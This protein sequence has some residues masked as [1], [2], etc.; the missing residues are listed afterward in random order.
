MS[1]AGAGGAEP[2]GTPTPSTTPATTVTGGPSAA[3]N[4]APTPLTVAA[5]PG[6]P[7]PGVASGVASGTGGGGVGAGDSGGV[8]AVVPADRWVAHPAGSWGAGFTQNVAGAEMAQVPAPSLVAAPAPAAA[9]AMGRIANVGS[10]SAPVA[11][12]GPA[13]VAGTAATV[14]GTGGAA[15]MAVD[16]HRSATAGTAD[17]GFGA[18]PAVAGGGAFTADGTRGTSRSGGVDGAGGEVVGHGPV[19]GSGAVPVT[20]R[21]AEALPGPADFVD[22]GA[23][24]PPALSPG[25]RGDAT[26][27]P[28][29]GAGAGSSPTH[30][31][32]PDPASAAVAPALRPDPAPLSAAGT[33]VTGTGTGAGLP[34]EARLDV[35]EV[36]GSHGSSGAGTE[37]GGDGPAASRPEPAQPVMVDGLWGYSQVVGVNR[38]R[39]DGR[40][41]GYT[42]NCAAAVVATHNTLIS[43]VSEVALPSAGPV[44]TELLERAFGSVYRPVV[45][46][47]AGVERLLGPVRGAQGSLV[48][49]SGKGLGHAVNVT[50][51][52]VTG[53]VRVIDG[54]TGRFVARDQVTS[55]RVWFMPHPATKKVR[56]PDHA[57]AAAGPSAVWEVPGRRPDLVGLGERTPAAVGPLLP[58]RGRDGAAE[59]ALTTAPPDAVMPRAG[60]RVGGEGLA[61][62][63]LAETPRPPESAGTAAGMSGGPGAEQHH[64]S[65]FAPQE[66]RRS[67]PGWIS[68]IPDFDPG[69]RRWVLAP[70]AYGRENILVMADTVNEG[71]LLG[72][73][74]RLTD[75]ATRVLAVREAGQA[76]AVNVDTKVS[77]VVAGWADM[78]DGSRTRPVHLWLASEFRGF[79]APGPEPWVSPARMAE[80]IV[81]HPGFQKITRGEVRPPL[82]VTTRSSYP[83]GSSFS[84]ERTAS[85]LRELAARTGPWQTFHYQGNIKVSDDF[86]C[87]FELPAG[88]EYRQGDGLQ[89]RDVRYDAAGSVFDF[90]GM[91]GSGEF[92]RFADAVTANRLAVAV[93]W[94]E[95]APVVVAL[96]AFGT[97]GRIRLQQGKFLDIGGAE[98]ADL[99]LQDKAFRAGLDRG[100]PVVLLADA[101]R[102]VGGFGFDFAGRLRKEKLFND[103]Y[104]ATGD[105]GDTAHPGVEFAL[106]SHWRT[107]D[108]RI[109]T[110]SAA[111]GSATPQ[112]IFVRS[113]GDEA[114]L[115]RAQSWVR[116]EFFRLDHYLAPGPFGG[117]LPGLKARPREVPWAYPPGII[118]A[119]SDKNGYRAIRS[120]GVPATV[121]AGELA[122]VLRDDP[123]LRA[124]L[125]NER[126]V[127]GRP[128]VERAVLLATLGAGVTGLR[129]FAHGLVAG[130]Y[131]RTVYAPCGVL[132]LKDD[133]PLF[134]NGDGFDRVAPVV[135]GPHQLISYTLGDAE[136]GISG[137]YFPTADFDEPMF[138]LLAA[139]KT[140]RIYFSMTR[141]S[142]GGQGTD[143]V[144]VP[145]LMPARAARSWTV[146]AHGW[147]GQGFTYSMVTGIRHRRGDRVVLNDWPAAE[148]IYGSSIFKQANPDREAGVLLVACRAN[149]R[150]ASGRLTPA[151]RMKRGWEKARKEQL[152]FYAAGNNVVMPW[153]YPAYVVEGGKHFGVV[154]ELLRPIP[155][156]DLATNSIAA[157]DVPASAVGQSGDRFAPVRAAARRTARAAAWRLANQSALPVVEITGGGSGD[158]VRGVFRA[159]FA[160]EAARLTRYELPVA[161]EDIELRAAGPG[162]NFRGTTR[163]EIRLP[164]RPLGEEAIDRADPL[165]IARA[166]S[167]LDPAL[168]R[169]GQVRLWRPPDNAPLTAV[170]LGSGRYERGAE[171]AV[172]AA[173][174]DAVIPWGMGT[175]LGPAVP[176]SFPGLAPD[177]WQEVAFGLPEPAESA[178]F[179]PAP[180][181]PGEGLADMSAGPY[182]IPATRPDGTDVLT[183]HERADLL[184]WPPVSDGDPG[185]FLKFLEA[186]RKAGRV[187]SRWS[188]ARDASGKLVDKRVIGLVQEWALR[189]LGKP[190]R[191][192]LRKGKIY[193]L[194]W[195]AKLSGA[196][197][198]STLS[199]W[200][201]A[202][203]WRRGLEWR[204]APDGQ[205]APTLLDFLQAEQKAGRAPK[206]WSFERGADGKLRHP[207][208]AGLVAEWEAVMWGQPDWRT[209]GPYTDARLARLSG[210]ADESAVVEGQAEP[211]GGGA[212]DSLLPVYGGVGG[213]GA[214]AGIAGGAESLSVFLGGRA[215]GA[216]SVGLSGHTGSEEGVAGASAAG[217]VAGADP[218]RRVADWRS[219]GAPGVR[220]VIERGV[221]EAQQ[222]LE[223]LP[224]E[225]RRM[226]EVEAEWLLGSPGTSQ[227]TSSPE[228]RRWAVTLVADE[229]LTGDGERAWTLARKLQEVLLQQ[230]SWGVPGEQEPEVL[231]V[232]ESAGSG[233]SSGVRAADTAVERLLPELPDPNLEPWD[234]VL[235]G[236]LRQDG[237]TVAEVT[238]TRPV[239]RRRLLSVARSGVG[240]DEVRGYLAGLL[241]RLRE[242]AD[243]LQRA[244]LTSEEADLLQEALETRGASVPRLT[245]ALRI[246]LADVFGL[247]EPADLP[248]GSHDIP[249][250]RLDGAGVLPDRERVRLVGW[251]PERDGS[252][253]RTFLDYLKTE[254]RTEL[255]MDGPVPADWSFDRSTDKN[256]KRSW[257]KDPRVRELATEWAAGMRRG[258]NLAQGEKPFSSVKVAYMSGVGKTTIEKAWQEVSQQ[259]GGVLS[260]GDRA[261]L[262]AWPPVSDGHP[263]TFLGFFEAEQRAGRAP[264]WSLDCNA[265]QLEDGR[266]RRLVQ[267][268]ALGLL[269]QPDRDR[270]RP[271]KIY[272]PT[273]VAD[274]SGGAVHMATLSRLLEEDVW[275]RG[276]E[277]R[278][279][280]DDQGTPTLL[281]FLQAKHKAGRAPRYWSFARDADGKLTNPRVAKLFAEWEARMRGQPDRNGEPYTDAQLAE[282]SGRTDK[283]AAAERQPVPTKPAVGEA[284]DLL[285]PVHRDAD[286]AGPAGPSVAAADVGMG[287]PG[288]VR[289]DVL[290]GTRGSRRPLDHARRTPR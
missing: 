84:G 238:G 163:V 78:T 95:R 40:I 48:I 196:V 60:I 284:Q 171:P 169:A 115:T 58:D 116:W 226:V 217:L 42:E 176:E 242:R 183:D 149:A 32:M 29:G 110:L 34:G 267:E 179:Q 15:G 150:P 247:L 64:T 68:V 9:P 206:G 72:H 288:G 122:Q 180:A 289:P 152:T 126:M 270:W 16:G 145:H 107:G 224:D 47:F 220:G 155:L 172:G 159:A 222:R 132:E 219:V 216:D 228:Q 170:T 209:G 74:A 269:G 263:G 158:G 205:G 28:V 177:V 287:L 88:A 198:L 233:E 229:L 83:A 237:D 264:G 212:Q 35:V 98:V 11:A 10:P 117:Q 286:G 162:P 36:P 207:R 100:R 101:V 185:T 276:L 141:Q 231:R 129:Q 55:G 272:N 17:G 112:A 190:D 130:G 211:A 76:P 187:P 208:V 282:L 53:E 146:I 33:S 250:T 124:M 67:V 4:P 192:R 254:Q 137:Q 255:N 14:A 71:D 230:R 167:L 61:G 290:P 24:R 248:A 184:A 275:Q 123:K 268:W 151:E 8:F 51:D 56:L 156:R 80:L 99:L 253:P 189:L 153:E 81:G 106:V 241:P 256:G 186:Q 278:P 120:D 218:L 262:L 136:L 44:R 92:A 283:P 168:R 57:A 138:S 69:E 213:V 215:V 285:P 62:A 114:V 43:G 134:V 165:E 235:A 73:A 118:F 113:P 90:P 70:D 38:A 1:V 65:D 265:K 85:F 37:G 27:A 31:G 26:P 251:R 125:G 266:V 97:Y 202:A 203:A 5:M 223:E 157:V 243:F 257:L 236:V 127:S 143:P 12:I 93:P 79:L 160:A 279:A 147:G 105:A 45:G 2:V 22:V 195:V 139:G 166:F 188:L 52:R 87:L 197:H 94:G 274:L 86:I 273:R 7:V 39:F 3:V 240:A 104:A 59:P 96:E 46:G 142:N 204:P 271:G 252:G 49:G 277:W 227:L 210:R 66:S 200:L 140:H 135:P 244:D 50:R 25:S 260:D 173:A 214:V 221:A 193:N 182:G 246:M 63:G 19:P 164:P 54:A 174:R 225:H 154:T 13:T 23:G 280:P 128:G 259:T 108:L 178:L 249:A 175:G 261:R 102:A 82:I 18:T 181:A 201:D 77:E 245:P 191:D 91:H 103:V 6:G 30:P 20:G 194:T 234:Q 21:R 258:P 148:A 89:L 41:S 111:L 161:L 239:V 121:S 199:K 75:Q 144:P 119:R 232:G 133:A 281:D 131:S 109:E